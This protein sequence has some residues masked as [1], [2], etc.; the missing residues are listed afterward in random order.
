MLVLH[1]LAWAAPPASLSAVLLHPV[2]RSLL[3]PCCQAAA[4][5]PSHGGEMKQLVLNPSQ[6]KPCECLLSLFSIFKLAR[7]LFKYISRTV[8]NAN[9][10]LPL[11]QEVVGLRYLASLLQ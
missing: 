10:F 8:Y 2:S 1:R 4:C 7:G 5:P 3:R 6:R 9:Y 11:K